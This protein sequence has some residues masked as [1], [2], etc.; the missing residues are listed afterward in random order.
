M[1]SRFPTF[2]LSRFL[3]L[4]LCALALAAT[5]PARA[6]DYAVQKTF[7]SATSITNVTGIATN[8]AATIDLTQFSDFTLQF[9]LAFTNACAGTYDVQWTT[10]ADNATYA[11]AP[12]AP[13]ASGWF[14]IPLTNGGTTVTWMTNVPMSSCGFSTLRRRELFTRDFV[15]SS[16]EIPSAPHLVRWKYPRSIQ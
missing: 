4:C 5:L 8:L 12:A 6:G 10:S 9:V 3:A 7:W 15:V 11:G 2:P 1:N 13:G 16:L 14:N